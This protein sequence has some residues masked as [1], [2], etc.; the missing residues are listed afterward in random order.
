MG[1]GGWLC[2]WLLK[3]K[4]MLTQ[5]STELELKLK[6][7]LATSWGQAGPRSGKLELA[8]HSLEDMI[9]DFHLSTISIGFLGSMLLS[10]LF[11]QPWRVTTKLQP[12]TK[13]SSCYQLIILPKSPNIKLSSY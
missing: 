11:L 1:V 13:L 12:T 9:T 3:M 7:S 6:L 2:G 10:S 8:T 4:L 5:L